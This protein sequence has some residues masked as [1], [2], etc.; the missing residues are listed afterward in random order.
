MGKSSPPPAPDPVQTAAAQTQSNVQTATA[1]AALNRVNQYSP[2][3]SSTYQIVGTNPDGTPQYQ[4]TL[5]FSPTEQSLFDK[6]TQ[7]QNILGDTALTGLGNVQNTYGTPFNASG[8]PQ[9]ASNVANPGIGVTSQVNGGQSYQDAMKQAQDAAYRSQTQYLDPQFARQQETTNAQLANMGL[10]VGDR[11][12]QN[13]QD[14]LAEQKRAAYQ[15]AQDSAVQAGN[16]E[17]N[18][19]Y[20]QGLSS[21]NLQNQANSQLFGQGLSNANLQ[22]QASAQAL[23]QGLTL[24]NQPLNTYNALMTGAQVQNPN[25]TPV[26]AT[27]QANTDVAGITN[28]AYQNQLAQYQQQQAGINNLFGLGGSLGGAWILSSDRRLK[29]DI[30]QIGFTPHGIPLYQFRYNNDDDEVYIG[31]MADEVMHIPGAAILG[32]DGY[33]KVDYSR[34]K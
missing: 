29:R 31:V 13:A 23:G 17:Q 8:L 20:G 3:G 5:A 11:A 1:N 33:W 10:Q 24:Y 19:L 28:S 18:V 25:F 12:Y 27:N 32:D 34:V 21:A 30:M 4:Q 16:Q 22:N 6:Y 15:S 2:Y 9:V 14:Q 7:G 26:P